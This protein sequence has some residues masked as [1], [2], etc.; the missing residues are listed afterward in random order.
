MPIWISTNDEPVPL[1]CDVLIC[2]RGYIYKD[3]DWE[4]GICVSLARALVSHTTSGRMIQHEYWQPK[5]SF[6]HWPN[7]TLIPYSEITHWMPAPS[8]PEPPKE[9]QCK[10]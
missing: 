5:P 8:L 6:F 10:L 1:T 4:E 2:H 9:A 7:R 3:G